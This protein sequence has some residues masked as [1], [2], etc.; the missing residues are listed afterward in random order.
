MTLFGTGPKICISTYYWFARGCRWVWIC[1]SL[2]EVASHCF[3]GLLYWQWHALVVTICHLLATGANEKDLVLTVNMEKEQYNK[4]E[5][6]K[7]KGWRGAPSFMARWSPG[8]AWQLCTCVCVHVWVCACVCMCV[9]VCLWGFSTNILKVQPHWS[10]PTL[11]SSV[12]HNGVGRRCE[13]IISS[14]YF[15]ARR[16][17]KRLDYYSRPLALAITA[18]CFTPLRGLIELVGERC[19][20]TCSIAC[21]SCTQLMFCSVSQA[22]TC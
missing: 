16:E 21:G 4:G 17:K 6:E 13:A 14:S 5:K 20:I 7:R 22:S 8:G 1:W 18:K 3:E 2:C 10:H 19:V 12:N 9:C 15:A 11:V